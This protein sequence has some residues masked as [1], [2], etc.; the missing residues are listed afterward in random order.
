M[1]RVP[2]SPCRP[3]FGP[4][5]GLTLAIALI[6][7][8][9]TG[10]GGVMAFYVMINRVYAVPFRERPGIGTVYARVLALVVLLGVGALVVAVGS[11]ALGALTLTF[12]AQI[13]GFLLLWAVGYLLL[14]AAAKFLCHRRL[15]FADLGLGAGLGSLLMTLTISVGSGL[16]ARSVE[17]SSAVYGVFASAV[18]VIS[19]LFI[20]SNAVVLS[21]EASAVLSWRLWPRG[22]NRTCCSPLTSVP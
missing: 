4:P 19:I 22:I 2:V 7:L 5:G 3:P 9:L 10:T 21:F 1:S 13:G 11:S 16:L 18:E 20:V 15:G 12:L 8:L 17:N 14:Y 6:G